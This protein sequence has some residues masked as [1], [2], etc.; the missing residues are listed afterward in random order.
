LVAVMIGPIEA[1]RGAPIMADEH[2]RA[3]PADRSLD[4]TPQKFAMRAA[5]YAGMAAIR[6]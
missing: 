2:D 5:M 4:E 6:D 3:I 1:E